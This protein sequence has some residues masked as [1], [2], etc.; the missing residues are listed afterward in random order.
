[1][2]G[3]ERV[4]RPGGPLPQLA[5]PAPHRGKAGLSPAFRGQGL[6]AKPVRLLLGGTAARAATLV[7][8]PQVRA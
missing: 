1:M 5:G 7:S 4:A 6:Q 3:A 2:S 8:P